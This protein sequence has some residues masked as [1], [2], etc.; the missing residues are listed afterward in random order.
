MLSV[1]NYKTRRP[2]IPLALLHY[3]S[4]AF[5][6]V[7]FQLIKRREMLEKVSNK[8]SFRNIFAFLIFFMLLQEMVL[9]EWPINFLIDKR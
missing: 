2:L 1:Y 3:V 8:N 5:P 4:E 6:A 9:P 7:I